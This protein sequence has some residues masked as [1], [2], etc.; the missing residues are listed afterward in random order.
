MHD[1]VGRATQRVREKRE[2]LLS[3]AL[4]V[5]GEGSRGRKR[6]NWW[7]RNETRSNVM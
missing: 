5:G 3:S 6:V 4:I 2:M 1:S 7:M